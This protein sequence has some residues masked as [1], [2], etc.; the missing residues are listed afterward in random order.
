MLFPKGGGDKI[1]DPSSRPA[2]PTCSPLENVDFV[3]LFLVAKKGVFRKQIA[4][5][6]TF[7][8]VFT[9]HYVTSCSKRLFFWLNLALKWSIFCHFFDTSQNWP[10]TDLFVVRIPRHS[11]FC[12][13]F[14][15][16]LFHLVFKK[17]PFLAYFR[18]K[19]AICLSPF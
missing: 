6:L 12:D 2:G 11:D 4:P 17:A 1:K 15:D 14:Y 13:R 9:S 3:T 5:S 16:P 8:I 19:I 10:K 7:V 18:V